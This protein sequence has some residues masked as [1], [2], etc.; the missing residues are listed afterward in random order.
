[1]NKQIIYEDENII[2]INKPPGLSSQ[3]GYKVKFHLYHLFSAWK[4]I[5]G[6]ENLKIVHR[7]DKVYYYFI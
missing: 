7:L 6:R 1:M 3:D 2:I 5:K 4:N